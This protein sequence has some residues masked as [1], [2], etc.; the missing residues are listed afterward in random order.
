[1]LTL[2]SKKSLAPPTPTSSTLISEREASWPRPDSSS[3]SPA[4]AFRNIVRNSLRYRHSRLKGYSPQISNFKPSELK[5]YHLFECSLMIFEKCWR[6][7]ISCKK[8][9]LACAH[10]KNPF[11]NPAK[12]WRI[13][14][15]KAVPYPENTF[16]NPF[17]ASTMRFRIHSEVG[18][19]HT[20][21]CCQTGI[22]P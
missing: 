18:T 22:H 8:Y 5:L 9:W 10:G 2:A 3:S 17:L 21:S 6:W 12:K 14:R 20:E 16:R 11:T 1:M 15:K 13:W 4:R 7:Q 19:R